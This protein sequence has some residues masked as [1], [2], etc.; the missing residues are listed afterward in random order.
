MK[1]IVAF[2]ALMGLY[3]VHPFRKKGDV[4]DKF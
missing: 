3:L 2:I 4:A 1:G